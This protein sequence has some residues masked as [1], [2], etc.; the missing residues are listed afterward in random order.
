MEKNIIVDY[1]GGAETFIHLICNQCIQAYNLP[2]RT[3]FHKV[4]YI[5][6]SAGTILYT[7]LMQIYLY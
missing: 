1:T 7:I 5:A 4:C 6:E 2:E 3:T